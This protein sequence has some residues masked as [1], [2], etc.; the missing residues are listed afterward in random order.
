[1]PLALSTST[2]THNPMKL[3]ILLFR[4]GES[5]PA[6]A[7]Q[8]PNEMLRDPIAFASLTAKLHT[9]PDDSLNPECLPEVPPGSPPSA[10]PCLEY[11]VVAS[12]PDNPEA[13]LPLTEGKPLDFEAV[14]V[15]DYL[16]ENL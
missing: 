8:V 12:E 9:A 1:M 11:E 3:R 14:E 4:D 13:D 7:I 5:K 10:V 15:P 16:P 6:L 2:H